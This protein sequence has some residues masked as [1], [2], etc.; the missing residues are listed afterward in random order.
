MMTKLTDNN[1]E[2]LYKDFLNI[3]EEWMGIVRALSIFHDENSEG[4]TVRH[5]AMTTSKKSLQRA[6][7]IL[8][9]WEQFAEIANKKRES[10]I[11]ACNPALY[12]PVPVIIDNFKSFSVNQ[13]SATSVFKIRKEDLLIKLQKRIDKAKRSKK[14]LSN[15]YN[16]PEIERDVDYYS[17]F[18]AGT[19]FRVRVGGY[20]DIF[21]DFF[22]D[23]LET[24]R[25][26]VSQYGI[27]LDSTVAEKANKDK[28]T[29]F[30]GVNDGDG[31]YESIY[32]RL[33]P[34]RCSIYSNCEL[35]LLE[36]VE[37]EKVLSKKENRVATQRRYLERKRLGLVKP[38]E[39]A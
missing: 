31:K 1:F 27:L 14:Q 26:R 17:N 37:R 34:M 28:A 24:K 19:M 11:H 39:S 20:N 18:P 33:K 6:R 32:K 8:V 2:A 4:D 5:I 10:G 25:T 30:W 35:Y 13:F 38:K 21:I 12:T 29:P 3:R 16:I 23:E 15:L 22:Y 7:E 9:Q 36:E